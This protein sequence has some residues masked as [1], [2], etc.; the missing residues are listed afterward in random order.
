MNDKLEC[1]GKESGLMDELPQHLP[2]KEQMK[3]TKRLSQV[4]RRPSLVSNRT[5][6]LM[7][8]GRTQLRLAP[9]ATSLRKTNGQHLVL[10][11]RQGGTRSKDATTSALYYVTTQVWQSVKRSRGR[12]SMARVSHT[13]NYESWHQTIQV[14]LSFVEMHLLTWT[15]ASV[16]N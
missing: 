8:P 10:R 3:A 16:L 1:I 15:Y 12:Q 4:T 7:F 11:D 6:R 5:P 14:K 9:H 2:W 13:H